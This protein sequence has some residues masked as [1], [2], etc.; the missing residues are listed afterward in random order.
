M[1]V[2]ESPGAVRIGHPERGHLVEYLAPNSVFNYLRA[3]VQTISRGVRNIFD[4]ASRPVPKLGCAPQKVDPAL[5]ARFRP[6]MIDCLA[7]VDRW[8]PSRLPV[9]AHR[10][11]VYFKRAEFWHRTGFAS[12]STTRWRQSA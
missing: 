11:M 4:S 2:A 9:V 6:A 7:P 3:R 1:P 8:A 10:L 5:I 12:A